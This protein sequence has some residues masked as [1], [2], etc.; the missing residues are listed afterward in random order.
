MERQVLLVSELNGI[1]LVLIH[2]LLLNVTRVNVLTVYV[3]ALLVTKENYVK[4]ILTIA[5]EIHVA[6]EI[7]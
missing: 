6:M 3:N 7:A 4:S 2:V 1:S 5:L